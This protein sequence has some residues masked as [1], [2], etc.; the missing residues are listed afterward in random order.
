MKLVH[1]QS[2]QPAKPVYNLDLIDGRTNEQMSVERCLL[3]RLHIGT[4]PLRGLEKVQHKL[5]RYVTNDSG[6]DEVFLCSILA[7]RH[8]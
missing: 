6:D 8:L 7:S 1:I 2:H 4:E 3:V 5:H